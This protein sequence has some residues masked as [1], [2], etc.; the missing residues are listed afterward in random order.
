VR[1]FDTC[2]TGF[3]SL[4]RLVERSSTRNAACNEQSQPCVSKQRAFFSPLNKKANTKKD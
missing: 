1:S 2:A 4:G 3:G